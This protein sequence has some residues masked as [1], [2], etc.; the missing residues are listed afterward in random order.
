MSLNKSLI[1]RKKDGSIQEIDYELKKDDE[2][3]T[4]IL[5]FKTFDDKD[6]VLRPGDEIYFVKNGGMKTVIE[7]KT[8]T[9]YNVGELRVFVEE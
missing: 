4:F 2:D 6:V 5:E 8:D 1:L 3:T 9:S 7:N